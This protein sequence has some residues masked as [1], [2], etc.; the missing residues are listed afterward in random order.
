M[1]A[2]LTGERVPAP[3]PLAQ[4]GQTAPPGM[5]LQPSQTGAPM[6]PPPG[7]PLLGQV[8]RAGTNTPSMPG[9]CMALPRAATQGKL[10]PGSLPSAVVYTPPCVAVHG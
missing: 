2:A 9:A 6:P 7:P 5:L 3:L 4:G 1:E 10:L 8:P